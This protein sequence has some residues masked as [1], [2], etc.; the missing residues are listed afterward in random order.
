MSENQWFNRLILNRR[1]PREQNN[2][3]QIFPRITRMPAAGSLRFFVSFVCFVGK[4]PVVLPRMD[5]MLTDKGL[6]P[7]R[8]YPRHLR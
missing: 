3:N 6:I 8:V 2:P 4:S 7:I 5:R 1:P